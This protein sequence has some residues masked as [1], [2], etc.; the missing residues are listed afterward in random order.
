MK[1]K[2]VIACIMITLLLL[3]ILVWKLTS[4]TAKDTEEET[5]PPNVDAEILKKLQELEA[6][7]KTI[8][9]KTS[10]GCMEANAEC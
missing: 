10:D 3:G 8:V 2:I 4:H 6:S 1:T 5:T 7:A 9:Y